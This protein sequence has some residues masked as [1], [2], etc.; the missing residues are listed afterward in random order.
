V[1]IT[2]VER[3]RD[4]SGSLNTRGASL[5]P[6]GT[7]WM[8]PYH[9]IACADSGHGLEKL[10]V[11]RGIELG[12]F[13]E[14]E[15]PRGSR[16]GVRVTG[17]ARIRLESLMP[18]NPRPLAD[19][20]VTATDRLCNT[21]VHLLNVGLGIH[22]GSSPGDALEIIEPACV[23]DL[24]LIFTFRNGGAAMGAGPIAGDAGGGHSRHRLDTGVYPPL[25]GA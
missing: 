10:R 20:I 17:A 8:K 9:S 1:A 15:R 11:C 25:D 18:A 14:S 16:L 23:Q 24:S 4:A 5:L 6:R 3:L 2:L 7:P 21:G 12:E 19:S 22:A 13:P